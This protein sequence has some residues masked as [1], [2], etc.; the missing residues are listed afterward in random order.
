MSLRYDV[1][2]VGDYCLDWIFTGLP[3][4]PTLG[5]EVV[6]NGFDMVPGGTCNAVFCLQRLGVSVGWASDFGSDPFSRQ[7]LDQARTEGLDDRLFVRHKQPMRRVTVSASYPG[8]RS[9]IAYYDPEPSVPAALKALA[10]AS[11]RLVFVPG[12]YVGSALK[13][14]LQLI[15]SKKMLL[16]MDGNS[17]VDMSLADSHV[18]QVLRSLDAFL[19]NRSEALRLTGETELDRALER[20]GAL[21]PLV[22]IKDGANGA[23]AMQNGQVCSAPAIPV[24]PLDTTGAGDAFDAGFLK[25]WLD[26]CPLAECLRWGAIVGGLST[27]GAGGAGRMTRVKDVESWLAKTW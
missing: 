12:L 6:A 13:L 3:E 21:C 14:G 8:E 19:P 7:I 5:R 24:T 2:V 18:E 20:L 17:N 11:A 9:F 27:L 16:A 26:G 23:V 4:T 15:H 22:V 25:A 10:L 1:I